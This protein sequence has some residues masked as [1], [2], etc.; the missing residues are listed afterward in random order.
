MESR[1]R[2]VYCIMGK[3]PDGHTYLMSV[4]STLKGASEEKEY[5]EKCYGDWFFLDMRTLLP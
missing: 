4:H 1:G 3:F 5:L 2:V